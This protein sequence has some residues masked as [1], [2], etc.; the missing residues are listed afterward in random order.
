A[1]AAGRT[2][3]AAAA[4]PSAS[5]AA[6]PSAPQAAAPAS[7]AP[8]PL[9]E[10]LKGMARA[11]YAAARILYE[12][13]DYPGAL[14][15]LQA[16]YDASKDARLLWNMAACEKALRHYVSVLELLERYASEGAQLITEEER[17]ATAELVT[18]VQAFVN[19]L[20]LRVL[21]DGATV[22]VDGVPLGKTPLAKPLRLDMGKR[23]LRLEK[24]GFV[25]HE[26]E[27]DLAG[28][29]S[30]ALEVTLVPEA[31]EG[32]LRIVSDPNAVITVDGHVVGTASWAGKLPS[33][34]HSVHVSAPGKRPHQT[35]VVIKDD[36]TS[37]LLVNLVTDTPPPGLTASSSGIGTVWWIVGGVALAGV[38]LSTY[39]LLRPGEEPRQPPLGSW[40]G[41]EL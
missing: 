29:K 5:Q 38:G 19:E 16:A 10:S 32:A 25:P 40:G 20:T 28:G 23:Q 21:P 35:E 8:A 37:S 26:A 33:G 30:A 17:Q 4:A 36:D 15:K 6:A 1:P 12:D 34:V 24:D 13:G 7:S 2:P 27:I 22:L 18:T 39:L 9:A 11:D 3:G 41:F 14:T 31:H